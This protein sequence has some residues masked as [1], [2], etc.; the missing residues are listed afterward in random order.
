ME[1]TS[2]IKRRLEAACDAGLGESFTY[3]PY[4]KRYSIDY[5]VVVDESVNYTKEWRLLILNVVGEPGWDVV[6]GNTIVVPKNSAMM[7]CAT[8]L[9]R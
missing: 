2:C 6:A 7:T 1:V 5:V 9:E 8:R 4:S 3:H